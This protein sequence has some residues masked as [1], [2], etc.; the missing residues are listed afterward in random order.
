LPWRSLFSSCPARGTT[1]A[2][3]QYWVRQVRKV[4]DR[5]LITMVSMVGE[6]VPSF[7]LIDKIITNKESR[8]QKEQCMCR[9]NGE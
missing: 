6:R 5:S 1:V 4:L 7:C 9:R 3:D 2:L 8:S